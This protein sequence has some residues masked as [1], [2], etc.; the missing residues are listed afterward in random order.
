VL[1][2]RA[3]NRKKVE[4]GP[5]TE[6]EQDGRG[7]LVAPPT[8]IG[9]PQPGAQ[10]NQSEHDDRDD[11]QIGLQRAVDETERG[12][13]QRRQPMMREDNEVEEWRKGDM[14]RG[15]R[16]ECPDGCSFCLP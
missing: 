16:D 13:R 3:C 10:E 4:H 5:K 1:K 7:Q 12:V 8:D 2:L 9:R 14:H 15:N 11:D 6:R